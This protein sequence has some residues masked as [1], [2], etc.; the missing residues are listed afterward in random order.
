M[1]LNLILN[2]EHAL[3]ARP[4]RR[5]AIRGVA[6]AGSGTVRLEVEDTGH[7]IDPAILDR[8][9]DPFFTTRPPGVGTGLGL[10]I[11]S[12]IV[13]DHGGDVSVESEPSRAPGFLS[14]CRPGSRESGRPAPISRP[15]AERM[16]A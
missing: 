8:V 3:S 9:F 10:S 11:V 12:G 7:G 6:D 13:R 16:P 14:G 4:T 1:L 2:A 15:S 5:L